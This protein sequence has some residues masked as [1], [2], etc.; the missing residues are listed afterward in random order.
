MALWLI[1]NKELTAVG[2]GPTVGHRDNASLV[3]LQGVVDFISKLAIG[4]REDGLATFAGACWVTCR[5][6]W[7]GVEKD[8]LG[9]AMRMEGGATVSA[10][11]LFAAI[12]CWCS[13]EEED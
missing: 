11:G 1:G 12:L 4:R 9:I 6:G 5:M 10:C 3:V 8:G 2:V 7:P 13:G